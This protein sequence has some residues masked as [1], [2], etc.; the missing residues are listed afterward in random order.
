MKMHHCRITASTIALL[1]HLPLQPHAPAFFASATKSV[2]S[3]SGDIVHHEH[4]PHLMGGAYGNGLRKKRYSYYDIDSIIE[5]RDSRHD[6]NDKAASQQQ[7]RRRPNKPGSVGNGN[8]YKTRQ[9]PRRPGNNR[10]GRRPTPRDEIKAK[11]KEEKKKR[12]KQLANKNNKPNNSRPNRPGRPNTRP[13]NNNKPN[14]VPSKPSASSFGSNNSNNRPNDSGSGRDNG[15]GGGGNNK[16]SSTAQ[17]AIST[18]SSI[19]ST[20]DNS[21]FQY[22][23]PGGG[24]EP[25][26]IYKHAGLDKG[27]RVMNSQ[28]VA[29]MTFYLGEDDNSALKRRRELVE[30]ESSGD[31]EQFEGESSEELGAG[32]DEEVG[33]RVHRVLGGDDAYIYGLVNVAAFLAQSMKETIKYNGKFVLSTRCVHMVCAIFCH[34]FIYLVTMFDCAIQLDVAHVTCLVLLSLALSAPE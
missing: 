30:G 2:D 28:G 31:R 4:H 17:K 34:S 10:P 16:L 8:N 3:D 6:D 23:A 20:I 21:L 29:G 12:N 32:D 19:S 15:G 13:N 27:L 26:T 5:A 9:R 22:Q 24:W 11:R 18:L 33:E 7:P 25:S 14:R 1:V